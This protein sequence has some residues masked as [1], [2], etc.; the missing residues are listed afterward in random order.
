MSSLCVPNFIPS[1]VRGINILPPGKWYNYFGG[2]DTSVRLGTNWKEFL[3]R[4]IEG[5]NA[6]MAKHKHEFKIRYGIPKI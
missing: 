3:H 2:I 5:G 4:Y 1:C 6:F